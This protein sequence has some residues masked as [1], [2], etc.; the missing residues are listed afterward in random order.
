[1]FLQ[2]GVDVA[3]YETGVGGEY[4]AT[5]TVDHPA[6]TGISA[7]GIDHTFT[8]GET[9][10][11]IAWHK[12]GIQ[13]AGVPS[14]TVRQVPT[15][16]KVIEKRAN[17]R[18]VKSLQVVD[19]DPRLQGVKIRP[20]ALFQKSNASLAVALTETVLTKL[21]PKFKTFLNSLPGEFVSGLEQVVWRG[22]CEKKA[23]GNITWY[24]DGA[25]TANSIKV[26]A[27]WYGDECSQRSVNTPSRA[28][29][30]GVTS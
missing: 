8:L 26:A 14:F 23:E 11:K 29:L 21:D 30:H 25:H 7:L 16:M 4:D 10:D 12:A 9:I 1:M 3:I 28:I 6:V 19:T 18:N 2:E 27:A 17:E 22:R 24:L 20:D 13:K 5:N 15:A